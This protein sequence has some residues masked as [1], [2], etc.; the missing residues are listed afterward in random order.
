[1]THIYRPGWT[2]VIGPR[3]RHWHR[4]VRLFRDLCPWPSRPR[5]RERGFWQP[6]AAE[7]REGPPSVPGIVL[8]HRG[9]RYIGVINW[10][11]EA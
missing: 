11:G 7:V 5:P 10:D 9:R 1:M 2:L 3:S 4:F 8:K 6:Y